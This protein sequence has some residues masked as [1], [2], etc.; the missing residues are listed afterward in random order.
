MQGLEL[1]RYRVLIK[2]RA[3]GVP[4]AYLVGEKEFMSLTFE[5][6]RQVLI[7]RPDTEVLVETCLELFGERQNEELL[8]VDVG[9]GSGNIAVAL[10][11]YWPKARVIGIDVSKKA[12]EV[13]KRNAGRQR[14]R[15]PGHLYEGDLLSPLEG[16]KLKGKVDLIAANLPYIPSNELPHL[17]REVLQEP[18]SALDGAGWSE[19]LQSAASAG[20][21]LLKPEGY[22]VIEIGPTRAKQPENCLK[23]NPGTMSR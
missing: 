20:V 22:L 18:I 7:P 3:E 11:H 23:K 15:G 4:T 2:Q 1:A 14:S 16:L 13:A 6:N 5:V 19:V 17:M 8:A 9:T 21:G 10:A 12:L